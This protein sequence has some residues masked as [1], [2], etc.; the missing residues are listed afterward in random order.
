MDILV[1]PGDGIGPEITQ[2]TVAAIEALDHR[3]ALE[4]DLHEEEI[5]LGSLARHGTTLT[6]AVC[7]MAMWA[8]GTILGPTSTLDY[9]PPEIEWLRFGC[10]VDDSLARKTVGFSP[11]LGLAETL[12]LLQDTPAYRATA[13]KS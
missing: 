4:I 13:K 12:R 1:L 6:D 7:E 3:Y 2:A 9:P 11:T 10:L 5:G 8:D